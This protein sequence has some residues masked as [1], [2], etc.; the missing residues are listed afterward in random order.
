MSRMPLVL[1]SALLALC[2]AAIPVAAQGD[3]NLEQIAR[4]I[5]AEAT[6]TNDDPLGRPLPLAA[7]WN[8]GNFRG[9]L[10]FSPDWQMARIVE[11]HHLLPWFAFPTGEVTEQSL[12]HYEAALR[13]CAE[14]GLP[15]SFVGTQYESTMGNEPYFSLP[16]DQNPNLLKTDGTFAKAADPFGPVEPWRAIG[17][18]WTD[19]PLMRKLQELYP[20]PPL[21]MIVSNNEFPKLKWPQV[22]TS[23]RYLDLYG[24]GRPNDFNREVIG[25]G[26]IERYRALQEG[27]REGFISPAWAESVIFVGYG[28]AGPPH[29]GRWYGWA[30]YSLHTPGCISPWPLAWDGG[31]PSYY[32]HNWDGSTDFTVWSPQVEFMNLIFMNEQALRLNPR[33]WFEISTWDGHQPT[34]ENDKRKTYAKLGQTATP[35]RYG[36]FVEFGL[37]LTRPRTVREFRGWTDT[38]DYSG[39]YF[40]PVMAAVD[41]VYTNPTLQAF[42]RQGTLVPNL[43]HPH[44]YQEAL[45]EEYQ[46]IPRWYLLDTNLDPPR[47]WKLGT[48]LPVFSLA[49]VQGDP[50]AR[51]WLV[52]ARA[53]LGNQQAVEIT[54]PDYGFITVEVTVV[55]SFYIVD[56]K[57]HSTQFIE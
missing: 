44:P 32:T 39:P 55:G 45:P 47:P 6:R 26:Y 2:L 3:V 22:E 1:T 8:R 31:S 10:G 21:V 50:G 53:P 33:Y 15:L 29:F 37:W 42:W 46:N 12:A 35:E 7:H 5:T 38:V 13:R 17:R 49:F 36:S 54:I 48:S 20:D 4:E 34:L 24:A 40:E 30:T 56:E 18:S 52:Y 43:A 25:E 11:G 9:G 14:L 16:I 41:R 57:T 51:Q 23:Q 19:N 27:M 28:A